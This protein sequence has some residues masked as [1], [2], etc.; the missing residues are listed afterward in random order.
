M[1]INSI[2]HRVCFNRKA[3][4]INDHVKIEI[5]VII[6]HLKLTDACMVE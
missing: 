2:D 3:V 6:I 1:I 4:F 5:N